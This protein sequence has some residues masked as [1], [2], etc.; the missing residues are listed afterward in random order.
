[1]RGQ[2]KAGV[3]SAVLEALVDQPYY[4]PIGLECD[5]KST[6]TKHITS[7]G[8]SGVYELPHEVARTNTEEKWARRLA[9]KA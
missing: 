8:T 1:M 2:T 5:N 6:K 7:I 3:W 4:T 9:G